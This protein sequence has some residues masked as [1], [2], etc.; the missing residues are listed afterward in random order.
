[1]TEEKNEGNSIE[2]SFRDCKVVSYS[3]YCTAVMRGAHLPT[4]IAFS[5]VNTP[6]GKFKPFKVIAECSCNL[7]FVNDSA[8]NWYLKGVEGFGDDFKTSAKNIINLARTIGNGKAITFGTS[9]GAYGALL[10]AAAGNADFSLSFGP[11]VLLDMPGSR[12]EQHK[13]KDAQLPYSD[14]SELIDRSETMHYVFTSE[15]DEVDMINALALNKIKKVKAV[16]VRGV[17]HPGIQVFAEKEGVAEFI[18]RALLDPSSII[19]FDQR[20]EILGNEELVKDLWIAYGLKKDKNFRSYL[21]YLESQKW[22]SHTSSAFMHRLGE[23]YYRNNDQA[24]AI[25]CLKEAI[26]LDELQ[27]ESYNLLGVI[28]RRKRL[29]SE[30]E[31]NL[32]RSLSI[33]PRNAF[34]HHNLGMLL[35]EMHQIK[36]AVISFEKAVKIN[37]GN[38]A[39]AK[40]LAEAKEKLTAML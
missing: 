33:S 40:S 24:N 29:H 14:F 11:E 20:G 31:N 35:L 12:S 3:D 7:I 17:E 6:R 30:A 37:K 21:G 9:M 36:E 27:Y 18:D 10:Y 28:Q 19:Q 39:F 4:L 22:K 16:S 15:C 34:A 8:N 1:M 26:R 25:E 32:R 13:A 23:A 38:T 2:D 5:S